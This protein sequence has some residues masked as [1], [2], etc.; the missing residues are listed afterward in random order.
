MISI[1]RSKKLAM[2]KKFENVVFLWLTPH[3]T[4]LI[5]YVSHC[6]L[7][8]FTDCILWHISVLQ[9][10]VLNKSKMYEKKKVS[11]APKNI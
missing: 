11:F 9:N 1:K 6:R 5:L 3:G 2:R 10:T 4:T 7:Q 8:S